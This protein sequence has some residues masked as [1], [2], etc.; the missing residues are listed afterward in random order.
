MTRLWWWWSCLLCAFSLGR[1]S[2]WPLTDRSKRSVWALKCWRAFGNRILFSTMEKRVTCIS[3]RRRTNCS[4]SP[5][6]AAYC[7]QSGDI[8]GLINQFMQIAEPS[9]VLTNYCTCVCWI[10]ACDVI[11]Y[12]SRHDMMTDWRSRRNVQWIWENSRWIINRVLWFLA[13]V[14]CL[15]PN[16]R[17]S[18]S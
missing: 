10:N 5:R 7:I 13:V 8:I 17:S 2:V 15:F 4:A 14:S 12:A 16:W 9:A 1:T 6:T 11:T 3:W 18:F